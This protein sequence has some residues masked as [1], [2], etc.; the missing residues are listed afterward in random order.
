M[1]K[2]FYLCLFDFKMLLLLLF[3]FDVIDILCFL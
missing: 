2:R 1:L 3:M